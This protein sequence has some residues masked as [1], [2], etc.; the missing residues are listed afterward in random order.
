[1]LNTEETQ[2]L[3]ERVKIRINPSDYSFYEDEEKKN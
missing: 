3:K 1:M 2:N